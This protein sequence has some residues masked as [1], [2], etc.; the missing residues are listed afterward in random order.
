MG[1]LRTG[2]RT[3]LLPYRQHVDQLKRHSTMLLSLL[4]VF[5]LVGLIYEPTHGDRLHAQESELQRL[6][7]LNAELLEHNTRLAATVQA[8]RSKPEMVIHLARK[9]LG[10]IRPD[11]LVYEFNREEIPY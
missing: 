1:Y 9:E 4:A 2:L 11:E 10:M 6:N 5:F 7:A 3:A 8:M